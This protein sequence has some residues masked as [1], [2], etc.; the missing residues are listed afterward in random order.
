MNISVKLFDISANN[1]EPMVTLHHWDIPQELQKSY[2]GWIS[3]DMIKD[4]TNFARFCF[5]QFGDRVYLFV[6]LGL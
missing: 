2:S 4:Y 6:P 5:E 1:I 3:E